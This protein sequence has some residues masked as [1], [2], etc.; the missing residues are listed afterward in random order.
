MSWRLGNSSRLKSQTGLQLWRTLIDSED[1]HRA[2]ENIKE[3]IKTSAENS[4]GLYELKQ[5]K[6]WF[7][8][9]CLGF[10]IK[11]SRL[12]CSRYRIQTKQC[13]YSKQ[14]QT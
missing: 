8:E 11:G 3:N 2:L 13:K 5:H 14:C 6:P 10:Q 7:D 9:E 1:I 12:K 4:L